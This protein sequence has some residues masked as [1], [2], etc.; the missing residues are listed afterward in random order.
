MSVLG[1][2]VALQNIE[3]I[4]KF[5]A[6]KDLKEVQCFLRLA[7]FYRKFINGFAQIAVPLT[8]LTRKADHFIWAAESQA[9][10]NSL[11]TALTTIPVLAFPNFQ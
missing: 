4:E 8:N 3:K 6:P 9:A 5:P 10:F 7:N 1:L 2:E 11:K